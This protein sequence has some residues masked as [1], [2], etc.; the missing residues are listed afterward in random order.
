MWK[1]DDSDANRI[2]EEE[3]GLS[4]VA[5]NEEGIPIVELSN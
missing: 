5:I 1:N 3:Y 4:P 2:E